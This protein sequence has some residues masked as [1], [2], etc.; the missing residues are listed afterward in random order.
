VNG[1]SPVN[2]A[3][4]LLDDDV[5]PEDVPE[6]LTSLLAEKFEPAY[7]TV[8]LDGGG[9]PNNNDPDAPFALNLASYELSSL[10][11]QARLSR[12][13]V[14]SGAFWTTH[15]L[16]SLQ[17]IKAADRDPNTEPA[18]QGR[19][20]WVSAF[21]LEEHLREYQYTADHRARP[22]RR[23][24]PRCSE[25]SRRPQG[26]QLDTTCGHLGTRRLGAPREGPDI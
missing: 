16:G 18:D 13:S 21:L 23:P 11:T 25:W 26:A 2:G 4:T 22:D 17:G 24:S 10:E 9:D 5:V 20:S 12:D 3:F 8:V 1:E 19:S 14:S 6:P 7:V 15:C